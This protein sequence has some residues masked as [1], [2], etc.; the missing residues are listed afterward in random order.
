[1]PSSITSNIGIVHLD[2]SRIKEAARLSSNAFLNDPDAVFIIPDE[3]ER[4][5]KL[6]HLLEFQIRYALLYGE[7]HATSK[8]MEGFAL[9]LRSHNAKLSVIRLLRS[10]II[11][12]LFR[13]GI[14]TVIRAFRTVTF[15]TVLQENSVPNMHWRLFL[16]AVSPEHQ[17]RGHAGNLLRHMLGRADNERLPVFLDTYNHRN[18]PIYERF[19]FR[20]VHKASVPGSSLNVWAMIRHNHS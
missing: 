15:S 7:A 1:M 5:R 10:G 18:I 20:T 12:L 14:A 6:V 3:N 17:R 11:R 13:V 9:W 8:N 2:A 4:R 19:G 16:I